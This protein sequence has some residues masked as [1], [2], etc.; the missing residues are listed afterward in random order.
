MRNRIQKAKA[1]EGGFTLVEL[2]IVIVILGILAAV[3]VFSVTGVKDKGV[4]SACQASRTAAVTAAE[5]YYATETGYPLTAAALQ[6]S[7]FLST[8]GAVPIAGGFSDKASGGKWSF[9]Y[10]ATATTTAAGITTPGVLSV[11]ACVLA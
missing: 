5:A 10:S 4:N 6:A 9:T 7:G 8:G 1:N 11:G 2:L 3:V